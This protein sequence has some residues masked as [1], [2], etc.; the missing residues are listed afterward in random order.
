MFFSQNKS[1]SASVSTKNTASRTELVLPHNALSLLWVTKHRQQLL[2]SWI[3]T[4][5]HPGSLDSLDFIYYLLVYTVLEMVIVVKCPSVVTPTTL[6]NL[7]PPWI[8]GKLNF[9]RAF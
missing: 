3:K 9:L 8:R 4:W 1:A 2:D 6:L 5:I 7:N